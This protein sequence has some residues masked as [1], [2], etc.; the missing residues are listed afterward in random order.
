MKRN[1]FGIASIVLGIATVVLD[2]LN[3]KK[4]H[5]SIVQ[6]VRADIIKELEYAGLI[7]KN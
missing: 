1:W 7:E 3:S 6:E 4:E 5:D 2:A